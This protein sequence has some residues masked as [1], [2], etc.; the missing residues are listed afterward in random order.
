MLIQK[1][2]GNAIPSTVHE[3]V[4]K[5]N[6]DGQASHNSQIFNFES[7]LAAT[8]NFSTENKLGEHGFG[9]VIIRLVLSL[10]LSLSRGMIMELK[11]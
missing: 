2:G 11:T 1:I 4:M 3:K 10:S 9:L 8:S 5:Q 7:I 6:K